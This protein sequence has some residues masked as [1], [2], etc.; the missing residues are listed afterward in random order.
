MQ[1]ARDGEIEG[2]ARLPGHDGGP[3][4]SR[5]VAAARRHR[6]GVVDVTHAADRVLDGAIAGA[7]AQIAFERGGKIV[8]LGLVQARGGDDHAGRAKSALETLRLQEGTLHR[9]QRAA[10]REAFDGR[11]LAAV[12]AKRGNQAT[13]HGFAVQEHAAG[14]AIAGIAA[15]LHPVM[16]ELPQE[17]AQALAGARRHR[18]RNAVDDI[19]HGVA[20]GDNSRRI[21]SASCKVMCLRQAG[22]P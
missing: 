16:P 1:Q 7:A 15:L 18:I 10:R 11:D 19:A 20:P 14:A 17:G 9:M 12:G 6:I 22:A 8:A 5:K 2:V 13:V 3:G 4:G 21:S